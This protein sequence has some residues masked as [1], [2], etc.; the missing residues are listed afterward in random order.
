MNSRP[1]IDWADTSQFDG[2]NDDVAAAEIDWADTSK[3]D[4]VCDDA[5]A[6]DLD[7]SDNDDIPL[8]GPNKQP[9]LGTGGR[10]SKHDH[11]ISNACIDDAYYRI[12]SKTQERK[13]ACDCSTGNCVDMFTKI[14]IKE[15]RSFLWHCRDE[16]A[17]V[18]FLSKLIAAGKPD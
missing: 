7:I 16:A 11:L 15:I 10:M 3:F 6:S 12:D 14:E 9:A 8:L 5:E 2:T 13:P 1:S 4:D 17:V 18:I